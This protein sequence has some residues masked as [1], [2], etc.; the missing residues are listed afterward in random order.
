MIVTPP[1]TATSASSLTDE[2]KI[3]TKES[4]SSLGQSDFL[5]LLMAQ[6]KHQDPL[7]PMDNTDFT[8]QMAQFSSLEQLMNINKSLETLT[9]SSSASGAAQA[10]ALIGKEITAKGSSVQV[11]NGSASDIVFNLEDTAAEGAVVIED[12]YGNVV[13]K[14]DLGSMS[15]GEKKIEWNGR[16]DFGAP[17]ADGQY[18]YSVIAKNISGDL[19]DSETFMKGKV[20]G[21][22]FEDGVAYAHVG[23]LKFL[24]DEVLEVREPKA[25]KAD[26]GSGDGADPD[27]ET[28]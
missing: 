4:K 25:S 26:L 14:I 6:L 11:E 17:L 7:N 23:D 3:E 8:A 12:E 27:D 18:T 9:E 13:R 21:V 28:I 10:M 16:D 19:V 15:P 20:T 1:A 5:T 2:V 22:S 24:L